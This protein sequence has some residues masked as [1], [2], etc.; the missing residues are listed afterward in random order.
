MYLSFFSNNIKLK[1]K[2]LDKHS[3][4]IKITPICK[5]NLELLRTNRQ[6]KK[7]VNKKQ[8]QEFSCLE[9][10]DENKT[11]LSRMG[12]STHQLIQRFGTL[13][14]KTLA[15]LK[16]PHIGINKTDFGNTKLAKFHLKFTLPENLFK[17]E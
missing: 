2:L 13:P 3:H 11:A 9:I 5:Y 8:T 12:T 4:T 16:P 15:V 1:I 10:L 17:A 6:K 14:R 7:K